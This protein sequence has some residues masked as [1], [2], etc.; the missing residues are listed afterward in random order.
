MGGLVGK[1]AGASASGK[2]SLNREEF[3]GLSRDATGAALEG[4]RGCRERV[5]TKMFDRLSSSRSSQYC[6]DDCDRM[7]NNCIEV[8]KNRAVDSCIRSCT[9]EYH[10]PWEQCVTNFCSTNKPRPVNDEYRFCDSNNRSIELCVE[11][12]NRCIAKCN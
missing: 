12:N 11:D 4:D 2:G 9:N 1:L 3:E 6:R 8:A 10:I 7:K 5:F